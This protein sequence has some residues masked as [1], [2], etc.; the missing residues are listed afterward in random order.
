MPFDP[1][2]VW[3]TKPRWSSCRNGNLNQQP[4]PEFLD[5]IGS[6]KPDRS[7]ARIQKNQIKENVAFRTREQRLTALLPD[8]NFSNWIVRAVSV[9]QAS[10]GSA[11]VLFELPCE[12]IIGSH[13]CGQNVRSFIGTIPENS[14]LYVELSTI[15]VG[16]FLGVSG[17]FNFV[18]EKAAFQKGRSVASFRAMA[19]DAHREAKDVAKAGV[20][21][22]A[23][24]IQ[25]L[26]NLK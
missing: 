7:E 2:P 14:R 26:S 12:I 18:E 25:T 20:D 22:F 19:A 11:A 17:T 23:S 1:T 3:N 15:S 24:S 10:D 9:K 8:G 5:E 16:D 4:E 13:A 21:F 6:R